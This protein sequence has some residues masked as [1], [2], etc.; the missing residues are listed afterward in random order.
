M[1]FSASD[2]AFE[3]FRIAR[4]HPVAIAVWAGVALITNL[5]TVAS[6]ITI[7]GPQMAQMV[8]IS[9]SGAAATP[10]QSL[11]LMAAI[12]PAYVVM[13]LVTLLAYAFILPAVER[14]VLLADGDA[15][16]G[17]LALG[18]VELRH[19][20]LLAAITLILFAVYLGVVVL[21]TVVAAGLAAVAGPVVGV[22][23]AVAAGLAA[24]VLMLWLM[25]RFSLAG[26]AALREGGLGLRRSW[27]L[28]K[29]KAWPLLGGL[30]VSGLLAM[31]VSLLIITIAAGAAAAVGGMTALGAL[32]Q[33]DMTSLS[34]YFTPLM[35]VWL[36]AGA[37]SSA[38]TFA[39][40]IG[41]GASA[42]QQLTSGR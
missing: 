16:R 22:L 32:F 8:E 2:A 38:L 14:S 11:M 9:E 7:A 12:A 27:T 30:I 3:G 34:A 17:F 10:E 5:I 25:A 33:P 28:S 35:V 4:R 20:G 31:V 13:M 21:I 40:V 42:Y 19:M 36:V 37:A 26:P 24:L 6:L 18:P 15:R 1:S 41:Y 29:G 39:I 23:V